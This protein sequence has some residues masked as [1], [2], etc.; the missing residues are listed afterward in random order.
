MKRKILMLVVLLCVVC[1]VCARI[2]EDFYLNNAPLQFS[3]EGQAKLLPSTLRVVISEGETEEIY[4]DIF[5]ANRQLSE[6]SWKLLRDN[7]QVKISP[8]ERTCTVFGVSEG[9]G[10]LSVSCH[11]QTMIIPISV[12]KSYLPSVRSFE[13]DG[14]TPRKE[15]KILRIY[16]WLVCLLLILGASLCSGALFYIIKNRGVKRG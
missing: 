6:V 16:R 14:G 1:D 5:S 7:G 10:E 8:R 15:D 12:K 13:Y 3:R 2:P 9:E 11:G 4:V